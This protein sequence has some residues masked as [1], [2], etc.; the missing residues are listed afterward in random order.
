MAGP[1]LL[2]DRG[3]RLAAIMQVCALGATYIFDM[4]GVFKS[5]VAGAAA[6]QSPLYAILVNLFEHALIILELNNLF[7]ALT[8]T[9]HCNWSTGAFADFLDKLPSALWQ[10]FPITSARDITGE[11]R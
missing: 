9:N 7:A 1:R 11:A 3:P 5:C 10:I 4:G 8:Y 2:L 6:A